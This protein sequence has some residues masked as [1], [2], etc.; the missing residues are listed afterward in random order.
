MSSNRFSISVVINS[1]LK[2]ALV[3]GDIKRFFRGLVGFENKKSLEYQYFK[4]T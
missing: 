3:S 1:K 4:Y 2:N